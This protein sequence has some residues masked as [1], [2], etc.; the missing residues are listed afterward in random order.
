M[1]PAF[2]SF[3]VGMYEYMSQNDFFKPVIIYQNIHSSAFGG[4][5]ALRN[6]TRRNFPFLPTSLKFV[7]LVHNR[8]T[9]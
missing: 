5:F 7:F 8:S 2:Q 4:L 1:S 3:G 9:L 6:D